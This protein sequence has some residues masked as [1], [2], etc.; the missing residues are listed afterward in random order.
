MLQGTLDK[1]GIIRVDVEIGGQIES[2]PQ[3]D[4]N[5]LNR[6]LVICRSAA[7]ACRT[8][9]RL[10]LNIAENALPISH[11]MEAG[12]I[13]SVPL[14]TSTIC[15]LCFSFVTTAMMAEV[16]TTMFIAILGT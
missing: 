5:K 15:L 8:F 7:L 10:R 14:V 16:S 13:S 3:W 1:V 2:F 9:I 6:N 12:A 11:G 4:I